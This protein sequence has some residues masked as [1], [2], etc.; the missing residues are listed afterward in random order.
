MHFVEIYLK[1]VKFGYLNP[2]LGK[3]GLTHDLHNM[4]VPHQPFLASEN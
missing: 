3:L 1:N 4:V 2:I